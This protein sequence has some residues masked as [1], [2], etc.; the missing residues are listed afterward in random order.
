[1]FYCYNNLGAPQQEVHMTK[2][3]LVRYTGVPL[4]KPNSVHVYGNDHIFYECLD[5]HHHKYMF[6]PKVH[7]LV[8]F[9][10]VAVS[11]VPWITQGSL[12]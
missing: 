11:I 9:K 1:M 3:G 4:W 5:R 10:S 2:S 12:V 6:Q 7:S 8:N